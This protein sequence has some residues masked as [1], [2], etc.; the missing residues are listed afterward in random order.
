MEKVL[1]LLIAILVASVVFAELDTSM[2]Q[3]WEQ[4]ECRE[5]G[6]NNTNISVWHISGTHADRSLPTT[7]NQVDECF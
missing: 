7:S 4:S 5:F 6:D 3:W 1:N 2:F